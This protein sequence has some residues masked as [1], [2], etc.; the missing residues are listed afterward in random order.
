[1]D[2]IKGYK[3]NAVLRASFNELAK[4]TFGIEFED[5]YQL[6]YWTDK[7]IPYSFVEKGKVIANVSVNILQLVIGGQTVP[8]IQLGT[9]M[10]DEKY[11]SRGLSRQLMEK[12]L[13]DY[14]D[15][16]LM[17]LFANETVLD[18]YPK[19]GF[20]RMDETL[21]S[22][23]VKPKGNMPPPKIRDLDFIYECM[24]RRQ[25]ICHIGTREAEELFMFYAINVFA[26]DMYYLE[27]ER[28][29]VVYKIDG[30]IL[31]L[32]D[33]ISS[34]QVNLQEIINQLS[35]ET[36]S[37]VEFH[38]TPGIDGVHKEKTM[39][40]NVLFVRNT[41]NIKFPKY[42]KHPITSQA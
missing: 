37:K 31:H 7:Y 18:F 6:G 41:G 9:V 15:I 12:V 24:K 38:F 2:F 27:Q 36:T 35:V 17:Y 42:F 23:D 25:S 1:M 32:Y 11:R 10:T 14:K 21:Y 19:F 8:A 28:V 22:V 39:G 40:E 29:I 20:E 30:K 26:E 3:E 13:S 34:D 5:W 33:V 4:K 16:D